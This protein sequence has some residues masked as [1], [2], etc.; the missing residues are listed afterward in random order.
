MPHRK[1]LTIKEQQNKSSIMEE[2]T[3]VHPKKAAHRPPS[4]NGIPKRES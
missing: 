3:T 2:S 4:L 1:S